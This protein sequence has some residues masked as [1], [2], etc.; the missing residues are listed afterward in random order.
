MHRLTLP[1]GVRATAHLHAQHESAIYVISGQADFWW[2][3]RLEHASAFRCARGIAT[4][5]GGSARV[6]PRRRV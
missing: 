3:S 5:V 4:R 1:P 6:V 2:G